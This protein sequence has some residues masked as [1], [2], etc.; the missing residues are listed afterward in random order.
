MPKRLG[1]RSYCVAGRSSDGR[2][3]PPWPQLRA[4]ISGVACGGV[5]RSD[6]PMLAMWPH[7]RRPP[8]ARQWS[9]SHL[10]CGSRR[11][12]AGGRCTPARG[13]DVQHPGRR[14]T[15]R[16]DTQTAAQGDDLAPLVTGGVE[17]FGA[18]LPPR[19]LDCRVF[20]SPSVAS[21]LGRVC[22]IQ[23]TAHLPKGEV[24]TRWPHARRPPRSR[25]RSAQQV[26]HHRRSPAAPWQMSCSSMPT[27][28]DGSC[29]LLS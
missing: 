22:P 16:C 17:N 26:P 1:E 3:A 6:D 9:P 20:L 12:R 27:G 7:P 24:R 13:I 4:A 8:T 2:S 10:A 11:R 23:S 21:N 19:P 25:R 29:S 15:G 18:T 5:C 28:C 14:T